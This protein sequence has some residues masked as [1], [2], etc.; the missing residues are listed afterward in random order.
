M[1]TIACTSAVSCGNTTASG[2][3][4]AIQVVVLACCSRTACEVTSRLP[5]CAASSCMVASIT[6]RSRRAAVGDLAMFIPQ[7]SRTAAAPAKRYRRRGSDDRTMSSRSS[8][9]DQ[10]GDLRAVA[11]IVLAEQFREIALLKE[12]ADE[13]VGRGHRREQKMSHCHGRRRP[14]RDDETEIDRVAHDLVDH[15]SLEPH[16]RHAAAGEIV[17]HLMQ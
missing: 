8:P 3:W 6:L 15:R 7:R 9:G 1:R 14:E 10:H 17:D 13:D 16:G 5:N 4:L 12:D 11:P 2:G